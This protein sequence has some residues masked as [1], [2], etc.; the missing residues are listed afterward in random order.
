MWYKDMNILDENLFERFRV[1][2][3]VA[4]LL[5]NSSDKERKDAL[6]SISDG[7]KA[8]KDVIFHA[9]SLDLDI[10]KKSEVSSSILQRLVFS[11][12][13]LLSVTMGLE[14]LIKQKDPI[15]RVREKRELDSNF[16]LE[17]R[18]FPIGVIGMIFE[19]RP[20]ALIQIAGLALR[21]GNCVILKGGKEATNTNK[22]LVE[23]IQDATRGYS[24]G[25]DW[26]LGIQS[27]EDVDCLLKAD[28]FVD[29]LIPRGSNAFVR[30]VMENTRIP[31]I[32]HADGICSTF[33]DESADL[34]MAIKVCVDAKAQYPAACNT[35]ETFLVHRKIANVFLP[36]LAK[37]LADANVVV[38]AD[39]IA[40]PL[41]AGSVPATE[42]DFDTEFLALECAVKVVESVREAVLHIEKHG[43]HHTDAILTS[44]KENAEYFVN[45]VDS[46]DV[47]VNCSTRFADGYRFGLGAEVGISTSKF[48]AR[49]PVGLEGLMTTKWILRGNGETVSEYSGL[50]GKSFHHKELM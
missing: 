29:L 42:K 22:T 14:D 8:K 15:G 16:V 34:D 6:L 35:T 28:K 25:S 33:V 48:H 4:S 44:S 36:K 2:K 47:F 9:N 27:H 38:H 45:T 39:E 32:G 19:S 46:A 7:L 1:V 40:L 50:G 13:K 43:S 21:S 17:K 12:E 18:T 26:I 30:F 23:V 24:F 3:G 5:S 41:M 20:D 49:G 37:A 10:A 11:E 31:V